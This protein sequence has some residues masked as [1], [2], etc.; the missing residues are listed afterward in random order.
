MIL[1]G[2]AT[3]GDGIGGASILASETFEAAG[4]GS[5]S[6]QGGPAKRPACRSATRS[7]RSC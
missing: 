3:G 5:P 4:D 1:Y 7:W 2:A 6:G